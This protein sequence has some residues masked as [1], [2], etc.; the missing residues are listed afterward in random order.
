MLDGNRRNRIIM[1]VCFFFFFFF[2]FFGGGGGGVMNV[3]VFL[4][5]IQTSDYSKKNL[6]SGTLNLTRFD[7]IAFLKLR[8]NSVI[9]V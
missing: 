6:V 1:F 3:Y 2:F 4:L 7:C 8:K 5:I 9:F